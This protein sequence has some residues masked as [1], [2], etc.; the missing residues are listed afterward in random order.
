MAV[1][2]KATQATG[3]DTNTTNDKDPLIGKQLGDY[4]SLPAA[5]PGDE[6]DLP[7]QTSARV[8]AAYS[9]PVDHRWFQTPKPYAS[10]CKRTAIM[11][12]V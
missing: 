3:V 9:G 10:M 2:K 1:T 4:A 7:F 12:L 5:S 6:R 8:A 11:R